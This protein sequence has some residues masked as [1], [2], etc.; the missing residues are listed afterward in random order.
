M[1]GNTGKFPGVLVGQSITGTIGI[2]ETS[3]HVAS[4]EFYIEAAAQIH[5]SNTV[6]AQKAYWLLPSVLDKGIYTL[7]ND[8]SST[9]PIT[10]NKYVSKY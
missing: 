2:R 5:S 4:I 6:T 7:I 9:V 3:T 1:V 8:I 10:S